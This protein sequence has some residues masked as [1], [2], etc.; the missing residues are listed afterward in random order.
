MVRGGGLFVG[1]VGWLGMV[2]LVWLAWL[3]WF[4]LIGCWL[5]GLFGSPF[6]SSFGSSFV[7]SF[8]FVAEAVRS[9]GSAS[10]FF[11]G[12]LAPFLFFVFFL[13]GW[14][15]MQPT[16]VVA[17]PLPHIH[18]Q[19]QTIKCVRQGHWLLLLLLCGDDHNASSPSGGD[20]IRRAVTYHERLDVAATKVVA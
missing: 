19:R 17:V 18:K 14:R 8:L 6:G 7:R 2:G 20:R 15:A 3:V 13:V 11:F 10:V 5:V 1:F 9:F 4:G 16:N 12:A